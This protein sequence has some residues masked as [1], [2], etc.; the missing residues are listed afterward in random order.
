[1]TIQI[2][3]KVPSN[4]ESDTF[5]AVIVIFA[6]ICLNITLME[7]FGFYSWSHGCSSGWPSSCGPY[8]SVF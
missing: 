6:V 2:I 5:E 1:M 3:A 8:A 4:L 7:L